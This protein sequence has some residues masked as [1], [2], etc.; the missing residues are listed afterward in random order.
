[1][2]AWLEVSRSGFYEWRGR[3]LSISARRRDNLKLLIVKSFEDSDGTY[4]YR[5]VHADL[6]AW[7]VACGPELV[8]EACQPRPW[9]HSLTENDGQAGPVPRPGQP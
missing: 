7:S 3:T 8:R 1:M 5:R 2:H 6:A 4:G 9:R